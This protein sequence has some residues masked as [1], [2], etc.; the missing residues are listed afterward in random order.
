M[1]RWLYSIRLVLAS[2]LRVWRI[3]KFPALSKLASAFLPP[4]VFSASLQS[5]QSFRSLPS[6]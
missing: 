5:S 4:V 1:K 6:A 3:M 2:E